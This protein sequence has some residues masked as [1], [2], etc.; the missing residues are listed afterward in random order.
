MPVTVEHPV[1]LRAATFHGA[2]E[3]GAFTYFN[4]PADVFH[5]KIGRFCSIG[6]E[7]VI[8]PG[9]HPT[10]HLSTHPFAFGGG[11][12]RFK[13]SREYDAI[14]ARGG[15]TAT[16][17][18]RTTVI[19][20]DVWLGTRAYISQGVTIGAGSIV[21]A[22]A[23]VTKDV[24]PFSIVGG[25]PAKLIRPRFEAPIVERLLALA[26]WDYSMARDDVGD[27]RFD[28]IERA[29]DQLE[30]LK[31]RGALKPAHYPVK[32]RGSRWYQRLLR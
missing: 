29:L 8:G 9:E 6:P 11:G 30:E 10:D 32:R 2:C 20:P 22:G 25:V 7:V 1:S 21:A 28:D 31:V 4:G 23:I 13:K 12:N 16:A 3:V 24:P 14:R 18:H 19:G 26:W 17:K 15:S 5:A 27:L